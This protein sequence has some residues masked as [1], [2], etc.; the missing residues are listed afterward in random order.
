MTDM[1]WCTPYDKEQEAAT[2]PVKVRIGESP[3]EIVH[4]LTGEVTVYGHL[5]S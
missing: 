4:S 3:F 1:M 5:E 2:V